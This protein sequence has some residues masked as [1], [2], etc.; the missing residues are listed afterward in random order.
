MTCTVEG[1][2]LHITLK[3]VGSFIEIGGMANYLNLRQIQE[4]LAPY[5]AGTGA[6]T[7]LL[8]MRQE[9]NCVRRDLPGIACLHVRE[10][11]GKVGKKWREESFGQY[12]C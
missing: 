3:F 8:H 4:H 12:L 5:G 6:S 10:H 11:T 9:S 2:V 1:S 7:Q